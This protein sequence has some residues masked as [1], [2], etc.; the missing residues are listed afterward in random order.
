[1]LILDEILYATNRDLI[2]LDA[3]V[4][5]IELKPERLEL[6][7]TGGHEKPPYVYD[8]ADLVTDVRKE[9]HPFEAGHRAWK[10]TE[11]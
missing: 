3:V 10:G 2:S 11:Y 6:V 7:L 8:H 1:M 5:L 9:K 4:N